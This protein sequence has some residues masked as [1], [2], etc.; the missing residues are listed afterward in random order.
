MGKYTQVFNSLKILYNYLCN[1]Y[2]LMFLFIILSIT[3]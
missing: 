3:F 2:S 1:E